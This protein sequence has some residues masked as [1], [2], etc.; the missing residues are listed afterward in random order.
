MT[1]LLQWSRLCDWF[2]HKWWERE[3]V[4]D[5]EE[6]YSFDMCRRC[7]LVETH[8]LRDNPDQVGESE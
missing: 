1:R 3:I 6:P 7:Y 5:V 2:G 8:P 4:G